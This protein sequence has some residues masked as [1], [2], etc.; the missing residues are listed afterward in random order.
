MFQ[1]IFFIK[2][3][4]IWALSILPKRKW[5]ENIKNKVSYISLQKQLGGSV[6]YSIKN[7]L[8]SVGWESGTYLFTYFYLW[9]RDRG[10]QRA[11]FNWF[12]TPCAYSSQGYTTPKLKSQEPNLCPPSGWQGPNCLIYH[13]MAPKLCISRKL[14]WKTNPEHKLRNSDMEY[15]CLN[16]SFDHY[17]KCILQQTHMENSWKTK[18]MHTSQTFY[19]IQGKL[20]AKWNIFVSVYELHQTQWE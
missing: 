12:I 6:K 2:G 5:I 20:E 13:L 14:K 8:A 3:T 18:T 9:R 19:G 10:R 15:G 1:V 16:Q 4:W 17:T 7:R 11:A